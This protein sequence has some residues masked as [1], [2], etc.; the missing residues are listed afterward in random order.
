MMNHLNIIRISSARESKH[1]GASFYEEQPARTSMDI[2]VKACIR[3]GFK[4]AQTECALHLLLPVD[5]TCIKHFLSLA[6]SC[7]I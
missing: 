3:S 4:L 7:C 5:F 1:N 6:P 2:H